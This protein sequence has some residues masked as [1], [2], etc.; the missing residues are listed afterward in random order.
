VPV[1]RPIHEYTQD[2]AEIRAPL[3]LVDDHEPAQGREREVRLGESRQVVGV[4]E[5]EAGAG[6]VE[7]IGDLPR[8]RRLADQT[9]TQDGDDRGQAKQSLHLGAMAQ[10]GGSCRPHT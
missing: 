6:T 4:L 8:Q 9:R 3:D 1:V 2:P 7:A 5:V 10:A